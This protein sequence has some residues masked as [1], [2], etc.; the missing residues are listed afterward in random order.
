MAPQN[1]THNSEVKMNTTNQSYHFIERVSGLPMVHSALETAKYVYDGTKTKLPIIAQVE[2]GLTEK[3][4]PQLLQTSEPIVR[5]VDS[6]LPLSALDGYAC[7]GLDVI[8]KNIPIVKESPQGIVET[9]KAI[10]DSRV[11]SPVNGVV[12]KVDGIIEQAISYSEKT[13]ANYTEKTTEE[14][15]QQEVKVNKIARVQKMGKKIGTTAL[16]QIQKTPQELLSIDLVKYSTGVAEKQVQWIRE[17]YSSAIKSTPNT[18]QLQKIFDTYVKDLTTRVELVRHQVANMKSVNIKETTRSALLSLS[19]GLNDFSSKVNK[20]I[21]ELL[22]RE[23]VKSRL[24][25]QSIEASLVTLRTVSDKLVSLASKYSSVVLTQKSSI[26]KEG[27]EKETDKKE[28]DKK[29]TELEEVKK[30]QEEEEE[31]QQDTFEDEQ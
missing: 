21:S 9:G 10:L 25:L 19:E 26:K 29:E 7:K 23:E 27:E 4:I 31:Q 3:V 24:P 5:V 8:E 12:Q 22:A 30:V 1:E 28:T 20:S 15:Q 11:I 17:A 16:H 13:V 18:E 6:K 2:T 14:E